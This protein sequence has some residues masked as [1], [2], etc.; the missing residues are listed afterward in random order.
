[1]DPTCAYGLTLNCVITFASEM[2]QKSTH[3]QILFRR[4][5]EPESALDKYQNW[6]GSVL[7][8]YNSR[9]QSKYAAINQILL[10]P[11]QTDWLSR[12]DK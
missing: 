10:R 2:L 6:S 11:E 7:F 5:K 9:A 1:M 4:V 3:T 8:C 12:C